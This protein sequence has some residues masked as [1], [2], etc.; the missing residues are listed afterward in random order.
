MLMADCYCKGTKWLK[1]AT[2]M[3]GVQDVYGFPWVRDMIAVADPGSPSSSE[4]V[5]RK[6]H[7]VGCILLY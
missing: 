7:V 2:C 1:D 5:I 3:E 4:A 6:H